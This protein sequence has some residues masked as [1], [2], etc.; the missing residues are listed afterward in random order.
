MKDVPLLD[1]LRAT[2]RRLAEELQL[3]AER[4]AAMLRDVA[5]DCAGE[6]LSEPILPTVNSCPDDDAYKEAS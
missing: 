4:Y 6:Y 1:E 2:R 3:D 5:R